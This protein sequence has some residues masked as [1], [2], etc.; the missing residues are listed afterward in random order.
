M[1]SLSLNWSSRRRGQRR[2]V[3]ICPIACSV[4]VPFGV[5]KSADGAVPELMG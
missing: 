5:R 1:R 3:I 2:E 4:A